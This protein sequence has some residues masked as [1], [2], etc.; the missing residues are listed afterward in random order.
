MILVENLLT[1]KDTQLV[2]NRVS[3]T[4]LGGNLVDQAE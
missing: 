2:S 3:V 1:W 4:I